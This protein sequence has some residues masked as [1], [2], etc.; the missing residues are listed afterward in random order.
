MDDA[1]VTINGIFAQQIAP[2]VYFAISSTWLPTAYVHVSVSK[3]N[4]ETAEAGFSFTQTETGRIWIYVVVFFTL[5]GFGI[6]MLRFFTGRKNNALQPSKHQNFLFF[7]VVFLAATSIISLYWA[8]AAIEGTIH[9][10]GWIL[11]AALAVTSAVA[12]IAGALLAVLKRSQ[13]F[14]V[15][16][17]IL[18][19]FMNIVG[20]KASLDSYQLSTPWLILTASVLFS[21][22]AG[23]FLTNSDEMFHKETAKQPP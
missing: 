8:A 5:V 19:L 6:L 23:F 17:V 7:G 10:F 18:P 22:A 1:N 20:V 12:G 4:W 9:G 13:A 21:L 11:M 14:V 16:A 3:N 15:F 2:G